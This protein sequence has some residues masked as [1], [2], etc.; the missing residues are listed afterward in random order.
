MIAVNGQSETTYYYHF[1]GLGSV[2]ALSNNNGQIQERYSYDVYGEP[3]RVSSIGNRFMFTGRE[4]DSETGNYYYR[5]RYYSPKIGRFL[6]TDPIGYEDSMSLYQYC[7][8]NPVNWYDPW[9]LAY[10]QSRPLDRDR[11]RDKAKGPFRHDRFLYDN[12]R[13]SGYYDDSQVRSDNGSKYVQDQYVNTSGWLNDRILYIAEKHVQI[14]W[15]S[16][17]YNLC[18]PFF[19]YNCQDY[20]NEVMM[21]Y[22]RLLRQEQQ[23]KKPNSSKVSATDP[24]EAPL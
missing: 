21:E 24:A 11:F 20:A 14:Y 13:D 4:Y 15:F 22:D 12:G 10:R 7:L 16:R 6:Q 8:N 17:K 1:D 2:V 3:N 19:H 18:T 5:A 9:G 23:Q